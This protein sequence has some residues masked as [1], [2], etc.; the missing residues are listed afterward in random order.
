LKKV[1]ITT[2]L[3]V[4][5]AAGAAGTWRFATLISHEYQDANEVVLMLK[6]GANPD[7]TGLLEADRQ[8]RLEAYA[9]RGTYSVS[10]ALLIGSPFG[11]LRIFR[12]RER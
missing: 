1:L 9:Q 8:G 3:I 10:V 12:S 4:A 2:L 7:S 5:V 11:L 6:L